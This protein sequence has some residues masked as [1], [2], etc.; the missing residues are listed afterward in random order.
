VTAAIGG[1]NAAAITPRREGPEI[2]LAA[3]FE[4]MDFLVAAGVQGIA[5]LGATGEF[6]H[7]GMDERIRLV[8]LAAKR[9][10]VPVL[11]G[12]GHST[13]DGALALARE[14]AEAGVAAVL[15]P[16]P[17]P[18]R[19]AQDDLREY[20][21]A[22][23]RELRG[24]TRLLLYNLPSLANGI[25]CATVVELLSTGQF[26]GIKDS[27]GDAECLEWLRAA[28][29]AHPFALLT[30]RDALFANARR[31]GA[32]GAVSGTACAVPELMLGLDHAIANGLPEKTARLEARLNEFLAWAEQFPAPLAIR[33]ALRRRGL[34]TGPG[35]APLSQERERKLAEFGEWFSGWLPEV[36]K[37]C[38]GG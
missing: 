13:F 28:R 12:V 37:E 2:D 31:A 33:H 8:S 27:S 19:Y 4:L 24:A 6:L 21:L 7:F 23:A 34:K 22:F 36:R 11:A 3:M 25:A 15:L 32:D 26:A 38:A 17:Y 29:D 9:S 14:A 1:I 20:Y 10:R 16:P 30:G 18:V 5:L 35:A